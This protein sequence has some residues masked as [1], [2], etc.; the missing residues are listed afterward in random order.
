VDVEY[1]SVSY[2]RIVN[3]PQGK[4]TALVAKRVTITAVAR[5]GR[6]PPRA[7]TR[8]SESAARAVTGDGRAEAR[9][10]EQDDW[11]QARTKG[12]I[13][14]YIEFAAKHPE[15]RYLELVEGTVSEVEG[16][17]LDGSGLAAYTGLRL[18]E[19]P[20]RTF[21]LNIHDANRVTTGMRVRLRVTK[22]TS[23]PL[24]ARLEVLEP[25]PADKDV[26]FAL[27][28]GA[29]RGDLDAVKAL[30]ERGANPNACD[31]NGLTTL[32]F[33]A[34]SGRLDVVA[35]LVECGAEVNAATP[36]GRTALLYAAAQGHLEVVKYL[37]QKGAEVDA[38]A[39]QPGITPTAPMT[40]TTPIMC[41]KASGHSDVAS[42]LAAQGA[43]D[44]DIRGVIVVCPAVVMPQK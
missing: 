44:V 32:M 24:I 25:A 7:A 22:H 9:S 5:E 37:V 41:A 13:E 40:Q 31:K 39:T 6:A 30:V 3:V 21:F 28:L 17:F 23:P 1:E 12:T 14:A 10:K 16:M 34:W 38:V 18:R 36:D 11:D 8:P 43:R 26:G 19:E 42:Y 35:F 4:E 20:D 33:G 2:I 15:S 27:L 29:V